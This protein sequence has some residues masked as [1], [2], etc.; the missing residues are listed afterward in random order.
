MKKKNLFLPYK[1]SLKSLAFNPENSLGRRYANDEDS[2]YRGVVDS[3]FLDTIKIINGKSYRQM[4]D[5]RQ[6]FPG[7]WSNSNVRNRARHTQDVVCIATTCSEILGLNTLLVEAIA[8]GHDIGHGAFGHAGEKVTR[9]TCGNDNFAHNKMSVIVAQQIE[10]KGKGL[11]LT[12]ETL[13][14]ILNHS[15]GVKKMT[16]DSEVSQESTLVMCA[17]KIGYTFS[18]LRDAIRVGFI[19]PKSL[20][21]LIKYFGKNQNQREMVGNITLSLVKESSEEGKISFQR[22]ETAKKFEEMKDWMYE[23]V[24]FELD[25]RGERLKVFKILE[26]ICYFILERFDG[27]LD[28]YL[29]INRMTDSEANSLYKDIVKG[30]VKNLNYGFTETINNFIGKKINIFDADLNK[31]DFLRKNL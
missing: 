15:R 5:R 11:N 4:D 8:H 20:P 26:K 6:V 22:S 7:Y 19:K 13:E 31:K 21:T 25:R 27:K 17:D 1:D 24:Y 2:I 14:G 23:N 16:I 30:T 28:P 9:E 12:Y 10:R 29:A 3:F 18:D